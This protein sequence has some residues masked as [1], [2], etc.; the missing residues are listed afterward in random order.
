MS[1][2]CPRCMKTFSQKGNLNRHIEKKNPCTVSNAYV[3]DDCGKQFSHRNSRN[4]HKKNSCKN[5]KIQVEPF[6]NNSN[7]NIINIFNINNFENV[8]QNQIFI[9]S[10]MNEK[11]D[12]IENDKPFLLECLKTLDEKG[13][14]QLLEKVFFDKEHPEN[15]TVRL[16]SIKYDLCE[17]IK[18]GKWEIVDKNTTLRDMIERGSQILNVF[19][20]NNVEY[21]NEPPDVRGYLHQKASLIRI[22]SKKE[23]FAARKKVFALMVANRAFVFSTQ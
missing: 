23:F 6:V 10:F 14:V 5:R 17:I 3:C 8:V 16:K 21:C 7:T 18:D 2:E 20:C 9:N 13:I 22:A 11:I 4:Y 19:Y 12:Y 15:H 1:F